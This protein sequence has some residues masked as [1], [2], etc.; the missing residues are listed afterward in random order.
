MHLRCH[1]KLLPSL[2]IFPDLNT[3]LVDGMSASGDSICLRFVF[4]FENPGV[5][6]SQSLPTS[7]DEI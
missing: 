5:F 7:A 4:L 6:L 2:F 3:T 1:V